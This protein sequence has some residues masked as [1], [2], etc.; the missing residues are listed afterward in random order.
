M[1]LKNAHGGASWQDWEEPLKRRDPQ[2]LAAARERYRGEITFQCFIQYCFFTQW[3][4]ILDYALE[5]GLAAAADLLLLVGPDGFA[6][7]YNMFSNLEQL[8]NEGGQV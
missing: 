2:A 8:L 4:E 5:C 3:R 6:G 1:A 7:D